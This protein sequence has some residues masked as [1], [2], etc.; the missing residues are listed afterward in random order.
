MEPFSA[1]EKNSVN[2]PISPAHILTAHLAHLELSRQGLACLWL[3]EDIWPMPKDGQ[4]C[5]GVSF[6]TEAI[7]E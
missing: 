3:N 5:S 6:L 7:R 4:G 2:R 1:S